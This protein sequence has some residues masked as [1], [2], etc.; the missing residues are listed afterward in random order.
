MPLACDRRPLSTWVYEIPAESGAERGQ[1]PPP[2][3]KVLAGAF[4]A[5]ARSRAGT[6]PRESVP[7]SQKHRL[8]VNR[9]GSGRGEYRD[10][11]APQPAGA[12][13]RPRPAAQNLRSRPPGPRRSGMPQRSPATRY[14]H[15]QPTPL[16][17]SGH[18]G[19]REGAPRGPLQF[20]V[21]RPT[22]DPLPAGHRRRR[23]QRAGALR[24]R[25]APFFFFFPL[26]VRLSQ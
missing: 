10:A 13:T 15:S 2:K 4:P 12:E 17:P 14:S 5:G 7:R 8:L 3:V 26:A 23:R 24:R 6:P 19:P 16:T 1:R 20:W 9:A 11:A 21:R 18:Q 22:P 25:H